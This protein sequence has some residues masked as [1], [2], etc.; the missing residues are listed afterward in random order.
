MALFRKSIAS[1]GIAIVVTAGAACAEPAKIRFSTDWLV[2]ASTS[3]FYVAQERGFFR[4]E[5]LDVTI[6][7][8]KG[9]AEF[10]QK[11]LGGNIDI[12]VGDVTA[13]I[14][15]LGNNPADETMKAVFVV[16]NRSPYTI[17]SLKKSG[18]SK[19]ADLVGKKIAS[20]AFAAA[21][22]TWPV[23]AKANNLADNAMTWQIVDPAIRMAMLMQGTVEAVAGFTT[24]VPSLENLGVAPDQVALLN[25]ADY[26]VT[27]YSNAVFARMAFAKSNPAAVTGFS[28]AV[29]RALKA[30]MSDPAAAIEIVKKVNPLIDAKLEVKV[31]SEIRPLI[32]T[33]E[34]KT[35]GLGNVDSA[36]LKRQIED[37]AFAVKL[38]NTPAP[39]RIFTDAFLPAAPDRMPE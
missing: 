27:F 19:P 11:L 8:G 5:N 29:G 24:D 36:R 33:D 2:G 32:V 18:I 14:Q 1:A 25:Y 34:T 35:R 10:V 13:Y 21:R 37:V 9:G 28:R 12:A 15:Y 31:L 6:E 16:G 4:D 23:F 7:S 30:T 26:G 22:S 3:W 38:P 39:D 17:L 20:A